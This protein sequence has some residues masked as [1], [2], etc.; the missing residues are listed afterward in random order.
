MKKARFITNFV[1]FCIIL[2][3]FTISYGALNTGNISIVS[4]DETKLYRYEVDPTGTPTVDPV[5]SA[6]GDLNTFGIE[7]EYLNDDQGIRFTVNNPGAY[8]IDLARYSP[9]SEVP[10]VVQVKENGVWKEVRLLAH[11]DGDEYILYSP[12]SSSGGKTATIWL[13]ANKEYRVVSK[14]AVTSALYKFVLYRD[15]GI[16]DESVQLYRSDINASVRT[17]GSDKSSNLESIPDGTRAKEIPP[18][19]KIVSYTGETVPLMWVNPNDKS[20]GRIFEQQFVKLLL[21]IGDYAVSL[22]GDIFGEDVT[23]SKLVYNRIKLVNPNFFDKEA[24]NTILDI[25]LRDIIN[26][27][28]MFFRGLA[29]VFYIIA[30][31]MIGIHVLYNSTGA[32][33]EKA[34]SMLLDWVKGILI[35]FAIPIFMKLVFQVNDVLVMMLANENGTFLTQGKSFTDGT[36]WSADAITFRSPKYI[37]KRTGFVQYGSDEV[38]QSYAERLEEYEKNY[39][40]MK[41]MRAYA[42]VT[43]KLG[44][45]FLW[46]VCIAQLITFIFIYVRRFFMLAFLISVFPITCIFNA[47]S[48]MRGSKGMQMNTW[49]K[50]YI[51]NVFVQFIHAIIYSIITGVCM[52]LIIDALQAHQSTA[53][54]NWLVMLIAINFIPEGEKILKKLLASLSSGSTGIGASDGS[55]KIKSAFKNGAG[56]L[57]QLAGK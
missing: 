11:K 39:D 17:N 15:P 42:G 51:S 19:G 16:N 2:S 38:N 50:E 21:L 18:E 53:T 29:L 7:G 46:Y 32:G 26:D 9:E 4:E 56:H 30:F 34:K 40:L 55:S 36:I 33:M 20:F 57:R 23:V 49:I 6:N 12:T 43:Q 45:C 25:K 5:T 47:I 54:L 31:L 41:I 3:S 37:S 44:F 28:Y 13:D 27:W 10:Y 1:I 14:N 8:T 24:T 48:I 22:L 35:L 52:G